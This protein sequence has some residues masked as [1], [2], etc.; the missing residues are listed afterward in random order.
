MIAISCNLC[1]LQIREDGP[2]LASWMTGPIGSDEWASAAPRRVPTA[3]RLSALLPTLVEFIA[4]VAGQL[5]PLIRCLT[6]LLLRSMSPPAA[7]SA[8]DAGSGT[9][10]SAISLP[11]PAVYV[12]NRLMP[13]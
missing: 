11:L 3:E 13:L 4:V 6:R 10:Y 1:V 9:V 12:I 8:I 2:T 7:N 5:Q